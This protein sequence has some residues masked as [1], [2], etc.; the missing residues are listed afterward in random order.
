MRVCTH[1]FSENLS[2]R[3][4]TCGS[5]LSKD[6]LLMGDAVAHNLSD[7]QGMNFSAALR[8][9]ATLRMH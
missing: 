9:H 5:M 3:A 2:S 8:V 1:V 6:M 4:M 7:G